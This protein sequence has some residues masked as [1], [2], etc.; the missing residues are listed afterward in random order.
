MKVILFCQNSY[1]YEI[2]NPI[3]LVLKQNEDEYIWYIPLKLL[4]NFPYKKERFTTSILDL[5]IFKSDIIF[6][7][8]NEVPYYLRGLKV[9]IFHGFAGEKKGHFKIRNYF[10]LYLTQGPYFT[11]KFNKLKEKHK[12]FDVIETG[13]P[14]LDKSFIDSPKLKI[15]NKKIKDKYKVKNIILYAPTFSPSLTSAPH[16]AKEFQSLINNKNYFIYFKFHPLMDQKWI[17]IYKDIS[18]KA[19]NIEF[20]EDSN[21]NK[22]LILSDLLISDTSSV[23]YEFI[24]LNKPVLTFKNISNNIRWTNSLEY[25][26]LNGMIQNALNETLF[27]KKRNQIINLYHPYNDGNSACRI[28]REA[29]GFIKKNGVPTQRNLSLHRKMKIKKI[30]GEG[31]KDP[32]NENKKNVKLSACLITYNEEKNIYGVLENLK[33]AD[34]I[35]IIDSFSNDETISKIKQFD[36]INLIQRKFKNFTD[37][38]QFA[39]DQANNN[40]VLFID[41]DERLSDKLKNEVLK[42]I[43]SNEAKVAAYYFKITFMFKNKAMRFSGTQSDKNYRLFQKN[44][45]EFDKTKTVH[46]TLIVNGESTVLNH[47]LIHYSYE[48]YLKFKAKRIKYTTMQAQ[49]LKGKNVKGTLLLLITKPLFRFFKHYFLKLGVFDGKKGLIFSYLMA[50]GVYNRYV[51]LRKLNNLNK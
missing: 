2:L 33:F 8:S 27:A 48:S 30:F 36:N 44:K 40:W 42:T 37:Q 22:Y 19:V 49:E 21:I 12:D 18:S 4:E 35:I 23:V 41:A 20:I 5:Q 25:S 34:E 39:L 43:N 3:K 15:L 11:E 28:V 45:V 46:E 38:K 1:A 47:K 26:N 29:Q 50:L 7:P 31:I 10:D 32:F 13:W 51:T 6:T 24:L 14:K 16:L 9:Q 17:K